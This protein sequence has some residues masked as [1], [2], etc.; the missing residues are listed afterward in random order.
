MVV[1]YLALDA[2]LENASPT[3]AAKIM[4]P[5][6]AA[7]MVRRRRRRLRVVAERLAATRALVNDWRS[8]DLTEE[9][10]F[11]VF[12]R[13][14]GP[15]FLPTCLLL[16]VGID[17]AATTENTRVTFAFSDDCVAVGNA[18]RIS[19]IPITFEKSIF[20]R[21]QRRSYV[22]RYAQRGV[23]TTE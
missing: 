17:D 6:V 16:N 15:R 19:T 18:I 5:A 9:G 13:A 11:G 22:D 12:G 20:V 8:A 23:H 2:W 21:S 1:R 10:T 7:A 3:A 14:F 4:V